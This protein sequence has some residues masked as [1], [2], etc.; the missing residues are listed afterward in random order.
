MKQPYHIILRQYR[1]LPI[2]IT[3]FFMNLSW[4]MWAWFQEN[5]KEL[6]DW[7]NS[8]FISMA[9]LALGSVK[10]SLEHMSRKQ[11]RDDHDHDI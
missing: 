10:W 5:H 7:A 2:A 4:S 11:E 1:I 9:L 8:S 6:T 3:I